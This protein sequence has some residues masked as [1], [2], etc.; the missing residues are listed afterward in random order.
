LESIN[1][2][3]LI[4]RTWVANA[5][6]CKKEMCTGFCIDVENVR[7]LGLAVQNVKSASAQTWWF[8]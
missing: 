4:Y 1:F 2:A 6:N 5:V 7:Q 3:D 8:Y